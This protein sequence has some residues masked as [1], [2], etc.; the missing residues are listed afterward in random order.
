MQIICYTDNH[1]SISSLTLTTQEA[2]LTLAHITACDT[3]W[4]CGINWNT[5]NKVNIKQEINKKAV[6]SQRR[7]HNAP[8]NFM[9]CHGFLLFAGIP[10]CHGNEDRPRNATEVLLL[11]LSG[12][13][14]GLP[15]WVRTRK[16]KR[17]FT[18]AR[19]GEWKWLQLGHMQI[20][21]GRL[22]GH[23]KRRAQH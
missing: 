12:L 17:G 16:V 11:Q 3:R 2:L 14:P 6:L 8:W 10:W 15:R 9:L 22:M 18:G 7:P 20:C 1:A 19:D 23:A 21:T 13:C 5:I 4:N